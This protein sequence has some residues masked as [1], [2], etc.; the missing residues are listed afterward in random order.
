VAG[1]LTY[2]HTAQRGGLGV[3]KGQIYVA[4]EIRH[5][6]YW[7]TYTAVELFDP[8]SN[9]WTHHAPMPMPRMDWLATSLTTTSSW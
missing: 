3:Y 6:D 2:A 7:A 9:T 1:A 5:R 8:K 4:G